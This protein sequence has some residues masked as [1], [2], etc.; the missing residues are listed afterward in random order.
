MR[1]ELRHFL[2]FKQGPFFFQRTGKATRDSHSASNKSSTPI[3]GTKQP[4]WRQEKEEI[5][6]C[7]ASF[8]TCVHRL[9]GILWFSYLLDSIP[10]FPPVFKHSLYLGFPSFY[11]NIPSP[12]AFTCSKPD[13][14]PFTI[15]FSYT[16]PTRA[17][18]PS[19]LTL[20]KVN[21]KME[22]PGLKPWSSYLLEIAD[23]FFWMLS[24]SLLLLYANKMNTIKLSE[25]G[26]PKLTQ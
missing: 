26:Q 22:K 11:N 13:M 18:W 24:S 19:L 6:C 7:L 25:C 8:N 23:S 3:L 10:L 5:W 14:R 20:D 16:Q 12:T 4:E 21:I 17:G 15:L 9:P 1:K 2:L